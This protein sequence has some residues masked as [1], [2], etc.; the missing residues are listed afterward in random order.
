VYK[1]KSGSNLRFDILKCHR[2]SNE[3]SL[4]LSLP[5]VANCSQ[6]W[7]SHALLFLCIFSHIFFCHG[8]SNAETA[9]KSNKSFLS[10]TTNFKYVDKGGNNILPSSDFVHVLHSQDNALRQLREKIIAVDRVIKEMLKE[11]CALKEAEAKLRELAVLKIIDFFVSICS[12]PMDFL[13]LVTIRRR[14]MI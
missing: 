12:M 9:G 4:S 11:E 10:R 6:A 14:W 3:L 7:Y 8:R 2:S 13:F 5:L 1:S